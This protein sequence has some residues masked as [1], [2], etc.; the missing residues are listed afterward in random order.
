MIELIV[1]VVVAYLLGTCMGGF[2]VGRLRGG[3]DLRAIGSGNVGA[4]N[5]LRTQ[6]KAF[7]LA[8]FAVDVGK[9][10]LA[11]TALPAID[12]PF[13]G[14]MTTDRA[15]L[16]YACGVAAAL[17]HIYPVWFGFRGG[18]G[19]ATLTGIYA[20]LLATALPWMLLAFALVLVLTG[21][22]GLSTV[23]GGITALLFV[24]CFQPQGV[25]SPAGVFTLTMAGLIIYTHR[26]NLVRV[27]QGREPRF[28]RIMVL[29][30]WLG[31]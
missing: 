4:T 26:G 5:A 29:R 10:V 31:P 11:A 23:T 8:V 24:T 27:W 19:A 25:F 3:V 6:G 21:Y 17:G 7:G 12:W 15:A 30:R 16:P 18:K 28:E 1:K 13:D 9:G 2:I 20:A 22:V 14:A